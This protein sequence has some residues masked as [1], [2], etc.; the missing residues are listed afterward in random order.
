[1]SDSSSPYPSSDGLTI[2]LQ[3]EASARRVLE[4]DAL[5][6]LIVNETRRLLNYRQAALFTAVD[7]K[8]W[9]VQAVSSL[10]VVDRNAPMMQWLER[11]LS[12]LYV[13]DDDARPRCFQAATSPLDVAR[14]WAEFSLPHVAWAPL[15]APAGTL[16]GGLWLVRETPW[17]DGELALLER[18]A[19][20]YAHAWRALPKPISPSLLQLPWFRYTALALGLSLLIPVRMSALAPVEVIAKQPFVV[21]APLDGVIAEVMVHPNDKVGAGQTLLRFEDTV[22]RNAYEV[23]EK[24]LA[25]AEAEHMRAM[26]GAFLDDKTKADVAL[27]KAK[28]D[29]ARAERD[30]ASEMLARI[31]VKSGNDGVAVFRDQA[32]WVGK[33]VKTGERIMEIA[34]PQRM[35]LR[36]N[37]PVKDAISLRDGAEVR[38]FFD[39]DPLHPLAAQVTHSSYQAEVLPGDLLD[40]RVDADL[41]DNSLPESLRIGWQGT[42]KVYGDR[43]PLF[44]YLF[45]RPISALRQYLGF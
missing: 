35:A 13:A 33:P 32:D 3:L 21:S 15:R 38:A 4:A 24:S 16:L 39:A 41:Q 2:L 28:V 45:R 12:Q 25:V 7:A 8:P 44:Y 18:L 26:Q 10:A 11:A 37:L 40:Y 43:A 23:A 29:L 14:D 42:A 6:F 27:L 22:L 31:E 34:D 5:P 19:E 20:T 17:Q 30:Y 9:R 1:M 36:I